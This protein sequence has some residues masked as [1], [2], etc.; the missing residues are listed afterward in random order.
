MSSHTNEL[1]VMTSTS[2]MVLKLGVMYDASNNIF[3][4]IPDDSWNILINAWVNGFGI[5]LSFAREYQTTMFRDP[6]Q[7]HLL[8]VLFL[9]LSQPSWTAEIITQKRLEQDTE[10]LVRELGLV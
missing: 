9:C 4:P 10:T 5:Q 6:S 8:A 7:E 1:R 3:R 2:S